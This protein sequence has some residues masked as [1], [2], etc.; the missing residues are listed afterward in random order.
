MITSTTNVRAEFNNAKMFETNEEMLFVLQLSGSWFEMGQQYGTFA[1]EHMQQ[2]W[3]KTVQPMF[4]KD[5]TTAE[6]AYDLFGKRVY[7]ALSLRRKQYFQGVADITGW[8]VEEVVVLDQS[9]PLAIYL[10][11]LNSFSGCTSLT[12][13]GE[14]TVDGRTLIGRNMDWSELF[15][16]FPIY[17]TVF[18]PTDGSNKIANVC[19]PGW[20]W[21]AT[22]VNDKGV[23]ADLHDGTSMGG[24]VL[25]VEKPS[26]LNSVFDFLA[27]SDSI[28][29]MSARFQASK[30]DIP[31]IWMLAD[32]TGKAH[33]YENTIQENR[34]RVPEE[35][36]QSFVTVNTFLN[37][38][39]G[40]GKRETLSKS[41]R[42]L[43]NLT[44]LH[45]DYAGRIDAGKMRTI[46][47]IP[48]YNEDG[49]LKEKGG[50]TKPKNQDVDLTN[51]QVITDLTAMNMWVKLP[52]LGDDWCQI[53]LNEMFNLR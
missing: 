41:L 5:I 47:D 27:E 28:E 8:T 51:Y 40:L 36:A 39:W 35:N 52:V 50:V 44:N 7:D 3:D 12:T 49:T 15:M 29:A 2:M 16:D 24:N 34:K 19:W 14:N 10:D 38:D 46:F 1:L 25:S 31:T 32:K 20:H 42:R 30:T 48:L 6:E 22:G 26:F 43:E 11:K 17:L 37:P 9:G 53:D 4:D 23:Y 33:S 18:N 21:L 13:W 45:S